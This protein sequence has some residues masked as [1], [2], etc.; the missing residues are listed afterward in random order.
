MDH[1]IIPA[2]Y[3]VP[4]KPTALVMLGAP[5]VGKSTIS[6]QATLQDPDGWVRLDPDEIKRKLPDYDPQSPQQSHT[7]SVR[8]NR[9]RLM[10]QI[11]KRSDVILDITGANPETAYHVKSM[12]TAGYRVVILHVKATYHQSLAR[13]RQRSR[14]IP[15]DVIAWYYSNNRLDDIIDQNVKNI[16]GIEYHVINNQSGI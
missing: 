6:R 2:V 3:R 5:A 11:A 9:E 16:Q 7:M 10:Q 14:C 15:T 12:I 4:G 13:N 8:I 1:L